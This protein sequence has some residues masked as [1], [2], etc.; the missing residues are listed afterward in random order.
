MG[1]STSKIILL[2]LQAACNAIGSACL[3]F[4][5]HEIGTLLR[6]GA[7]MEMTLVENPMYTIEVEGILKLLLPL[8]TRTKVTAISNGIDLK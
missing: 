7:A 4:T 3:S 1:H 8:V 2:H 5:P 6:Q